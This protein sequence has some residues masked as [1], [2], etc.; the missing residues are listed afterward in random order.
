MLRNAPQVLEFDLR[1]K[2]SGV[3]LITTPAATIDVGTV[4]FLAMIV[5]VRVV[6]GYIVD[7]S[8]GTAEVVKYIC[9]KQYLFL[10]TVSDKVMSDSSKGLRFD[11]L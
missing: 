4:R 10:K 5:F 1:A 7:G 8:R 2:A 11:S 9:G 3:L 6:I